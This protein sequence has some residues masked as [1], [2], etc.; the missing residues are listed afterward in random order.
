MFGDSSSGSGSGSGSGSDSDSDSDSG[1]AT[2]AAEV[3]AGL[4]LVKLGAAVDRQQTLLP[5][6]AVVT[7]SSPPSPSAGWKGLGLLPGL[8]REVV[9]VHEYVAMNSAE[10][11]ALTLRCVCHS[12]G[13][14][15]AAVLAERPPPSLLVA[16]RTC[17]PQL[18]TG[19]RNMLEADG[20][21]A[22]TFARHVL[23]LEQDGE[24]GRATRARVQLHRNCADALQALQRGTVGAE[25]ASAQLRLK[26]AQLLAPARTLETHTLALEVGA[27]G[28]IVVKHP[29]YVCS[30]HA[31]KPASRFIMDPTPRSGK[32]AHVKGKEAGRAVQRALPSS[33]AVHRL[34]AH[35][36]GRAL[37]TALGMGPMAPSRAVVARPARFAI[38]LLFYEVMAQ[39]CSR[40]GLKWSSMAYEAA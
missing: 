1:V 20:L 21:S 37:L 25:W 7:Q 14:M 3:A 5:R 31:G 12:A 2:S 10:L 26:V 22:P 39:R 35:R 4:E 11:M 16:M 36:V 19:L 18:H 34:G 23:A 32:G 8:L 15:M 13:S 38:L 9:V 6:G 33:T 24:A 28:T 27:G 40:L 17:P 29:L 30:V